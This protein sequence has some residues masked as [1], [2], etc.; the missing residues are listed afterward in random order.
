MAKEGPQCP[1]CK[2]KKYTI[3][4]GPVKINGRDR[5]LLQCQECF[6]R[7]NWDVPPDWNLPPS[8]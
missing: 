8:E 1:Q 5:Y 6:Y 2:S 3:I 4:N 7:Y